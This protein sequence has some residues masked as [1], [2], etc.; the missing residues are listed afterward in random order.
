MNV[1]NKLTIVLLVIK[2]CCLV[3]SAF[4]ANYKPV[5]IDSRIKTYIF[6]E[7]E[8]FRIV[9][10]YGYQTSIEFAE[11]EE[12]QTISAGNNYAWQ[13]TPIGR[14][15]F[16]K[17]LEENIATNMTI[18][19]N[20][21]SYYFDIESR[22]LTYNNNQDLVYV[23]RFF[24]PDN[25]VNDNSISDN[26]IKMSD[27]IKQQGVSSVSD[28]KPYNFNYTISGAINLGPTKIFD[29]GLNTFFKFKSN[30]SHLPY[31]TCMNKDGSLE[32]IPRRRGDYIV[33]N[34]ICES[35]RLNF[36]DDKVVNV[37]N[38]AIIKSR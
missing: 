36:G 12:I 28:V 37:F 18:L 29:D 9:V 5:T 10:H 21:R 13:I 16:I 38:E 3:P 14:R 17:P 25:E 30:E 19:T 1:L 2:F 33:V 20:K 6:N 35:F 7:N 34:S 27:T 8:V 15:L 26:N 22:S 4:A 23:I 24:Y 32:L 11:S 31:F